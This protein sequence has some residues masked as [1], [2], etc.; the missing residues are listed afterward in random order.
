MRISR[1]KNLVIRF[2][3]GISFLF[4]AAIGIGLGIAL[5]E[6]RNI[7]N[8]ESIG[9]QQPS[10]PSQI[11][12]AEDRLITEFF[13]DEKRE[14]VSI[15]ELPK[16]L[17]Y[18]LITREDRDFFQHRGFSFRGTFRAMWNII[19]RNYVSGGSTITQQLAGSLYADRSELT[20]K[21]KIVELWWAFQMERSLTKYEILEKYLNKMYFG[22][23]VYGVEA[24]CRFYFG[25]SAREITLAE[26]VALVIQLA[27]AVRYN[28]LKYPN[29]LKIIQEKLLGQ[30]VELGYATK[31]EADLSFEE[32]WN[33][34]DYTR[35]SSSNAF[36]EREDRAPYFSEYIRQELD[37]MLYGSRNIYKDG[38]IVH[39]TLNLDFQAK[40]DE[41]MQQGIAEVNA[42]YRSTSDRRM[43]FA[44][45]QFVPIINLLALTYNIGD[46]R[47]S[48]S[49]DKQNANK[50]YR[51][52]LNPVLDVA[53]LLFGVDELKFSVQMGYAQEK[54]AS[55]RTTV[56]GALVSIENS[57]G[58]IVAMV[59]GSR[60]ESINQF[61]R[62]VQAEI[63]PGS[64]FK[65][66]YY[67]AAVEDRKITPATMIY[68]SPKVFWND[69]GSPYMP[70]NFKGEWKGPVLVRE[71]LARSM[72]IPSL[73]VLEM[74]GFNSAIKT[75]SS[76]LGITAPEQVARIFPRKYPLGL[77][78]ISVAPIQMARAF[79]AFA[80]QGREVV[81][82][83]VRYI[84]N[85]NGAIILEPEKELRERQRDKGQAA[86]LV[87]S[88]T[89]YIMTNILQSTIDWGT[90]AGARNRVGGFNNMPMAG[91]TGTT[92]NWSD[93]WTVGYSPYYTTAVWFGFDQP[94]NSLGVSQTG[95]VSAGPVWGNFMKFIHKNLEPRPFPRP[96]GIVDVS[97]T[98]RSGLL[99]PPGY[100]GRV[101]KEVFIIGTEPRRFD[102]LVAF[103][104]ERDLLTEE[105]LRTSLLLE[106]FI[107]NTDEPDIRGS[108]GLILDSSILSGADR[109]PRLPASG[110]IDG[111]ADDVPVS[112]K[113]LNP[114]LD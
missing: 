14:I 113:A 52:S 65:P 26:S 77:G 104:K 27:N 92:Q 112:E 98:S 11:L 62:A 75:A 54:K 32:Y 30:M 74:V 53:A 47:S 114:H 69:D 28:P 71:A 100:E 21:R 18:A 96:E 81:P 102:D 73:E 38:F 2:V 13:S 108:G 63:Q 23:G 60:F 59:G 20:L 44:E 99:P 19:T 72:N 67:A 16:H 84:E 15:D 48:G 70:A 45:Q 50:H 80:N 76:L 109:P 9:E 51:R 89:A 88:Q 7:Q 56:E 57:T 43:V 86:Q 41:V 25:H 82:I 8:I 93:I 87:S 78:I 95:A 39:T 6:T 49:K 46:I 17:I 10:L 68:D 85:R 66:L 105:R 94:G 35:A 34:F 111:G 110:D 101:T 58:R 29:S 33:K 106:D 5:A 1:K 55:Q 97:V 3:F 83:G 31:E 61:N 22:S 91:K 79:A 12:D 36:F 4:A 103:E 40:A 37:G 42:T 24:A 90:L 64:S 107:K